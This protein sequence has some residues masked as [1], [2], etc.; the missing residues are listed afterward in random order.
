MR[1]SRVGQ[2]PLLKAES[3]R[4]ENLRPS[5]LVSDLKKSSL[6]QTVRRFRVRRHH[7][8][9]VSLATIA[10]VLLSA[11]FVVGAVLR[12]SLGPVSVAAFSGKLRD[13]IV[14]ALAG[15]IVHY[16]DA[17]IEWSRD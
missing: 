2:E 10:V 13:A 6:V 11:F 16:D 4:S 14:D 8:R 1:D 15:A 5:G 17:E 7:V 9:H 12:L 3:I